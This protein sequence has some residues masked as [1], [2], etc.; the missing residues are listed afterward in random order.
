M[1]H[2]KRGLPESYP[3]CVAAESTGTFLIHRMVNETLISEK[4]DFPEIDGLW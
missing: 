3:S 1:A 4:V 2:Q